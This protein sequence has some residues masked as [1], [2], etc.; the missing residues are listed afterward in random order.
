[1]THR[2]GVL[3]EEGAEDG[4][5]G[6]ALGLGVVDRVDEGGDTEGIRQEDE[7]LAEIGAGLSRLGEELD[8]SP[9]RQLVRL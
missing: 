3:D 7:L 1:M 9:G 4:R 6:R 5:L 2:A 8:R